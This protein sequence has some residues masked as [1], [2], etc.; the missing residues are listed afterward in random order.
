MSSFPSDTIT[1]SIV[2]L[3]DEDVTALA[4]TLT[5]DTL[6]T[7]IVRIPTV[8]SMIEEGFWP[9]ALPLNASWL[10]DYLFTDIS[11]SNIEFWHDVG[12]V[13]ELLEQVRQN[14]REWFFGS[15]STHTDM[16]ARVAI[17]LP[18]LSRDGSMFNSR[19]SRTSERVYS[20]NLRPRTDM[21]M[22]RSPLS[23]TITRD[24]ITEARVTL[25][26]EV[27]HVLPVTRYALGMSS[28]LY[29]YDRPEDVL[30]TFYYLEPESTTYLAYK[31]EMRA[32]NKT[33]ACLSLG[34]VD[35][36]WD[37]TQALQHSS[38]ARTC[39]LVSRGVYPRDLMMTPRQAAYLRGSPSPSESVDEEEHY[40]GMYLQM[41]GNEDSW[42]QSLARAAAE[43]GYDVV[44]LE[45]MVGQYQVVTE[46]LD[47]RP[48]DESF[49]RLLYLTN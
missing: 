15:L 46:V 14:C 32:F 49:S 43:Q 38:S 7:N 45:S 13:D 31:T 41:Y 47:T 35:E 40:A 37:M 19:L 11:N 28:G 16:G 33:E 1:D 4:S 25:E 34:L 5:K 27:W 36:E 24:Q 21:S 48:R 29:Y 20:Q 44:M 18:L 8:S 2:L 30:G 12:D 17:S 10:S 26:G 6:F 42:D 39:E 23:R 9:A 3:H 22:F